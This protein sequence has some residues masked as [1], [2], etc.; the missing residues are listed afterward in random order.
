MVNHMEKK[1]LFTDAQHGFISG[2]SCT[3]QLLEF[4][5]EITLT[6]DKGEYVDIIYLAFTKA[7]DK[8]PHRRLLK[9]LFGYG[10]RGKIYTWIKEFLSNRKQREAINVVFSEWK[11]VTSG[12]PQGS[13]L[14]P[15]L[16]FIF[17]NNMPEVQ[18]CCVKFF[19]DDAKVNS[20]IKAENDRI[21]LQVCVLLISFE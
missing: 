7:L 14:R 5:E 1:N 9:K 20:P 15:I 11:N 16:F 21:R 10:I 8:V 17:I 19:A 13:V 12:I 2:R 3:T 4:M 18:S 6:L